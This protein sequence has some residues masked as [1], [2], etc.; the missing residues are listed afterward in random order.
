MGKVLMM[1]TLIYDCEIKRCIP[2]KGA[3]HSGSIEY[4][5]GWSDYAGM[6]ISVLC[7]LEITA[8]RIGESARQYTIVDENW[9]L[10]GELVASADFIVGFNNHNFDNKLVQA[11][12]VEIPRS[13]SYDIYVEIIDAAGLSNAPFSYRKGYK[14]DDVARANNIPGKDGHGIMAPIL[15][16]TGKLDELHAYCM[17]DVEM[18]AEVYNKILDGDLLCP[19]SG[20]VLKVKTP[21]ERLVGAQH[22]LL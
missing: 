18:T 15:Y 2:D 10:F 19:K 21:H 6:G 3:I 7:A 9:Q 22:K 17:H 8:D 16:Q 5:E 1:K 20:R 11:H 4:C 12:G 13:K 14:L